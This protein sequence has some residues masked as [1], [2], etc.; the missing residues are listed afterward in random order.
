M[1][2]LEGQVRIPSGCA[3]SAVISR[4][5]KKMTGER[6]AAGMIPMHDRS[7]GLG[8]AL[9]ATEFIRSIGIFMRFTSFSIRYPQR[10]RAKR[11]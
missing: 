9:P 4:D 10:K 2:Q 6:V 7:N 5:G 3:I 11:C 8:L 1:N